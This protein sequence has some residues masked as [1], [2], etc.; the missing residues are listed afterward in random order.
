[1]PMEQLKTLLELVVMVVFIR[2]RLYWIPAA[3]PFLR[4]GETIF[5]KEI[6]LARLSGMKAGVLRNWHRRLTESNRIRSR[7]AGY[8]S[9]RLRLR[10]ASG[11]SHPYLRLPIFVSNADAKRELYSRS[12]VRGLGL[13]AAY[14]APVNEIPEIREAFA[15]E[16]FPVARRVADTLLTIP[17]HEWLSKK[18][19]RAIVDCVGPFLTTGSDQWKRG[20][21]VPD[22]SLKADVA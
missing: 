9:R 2:P 7:N 13:S 19:R 1:L 10:P 22:V 3:L 16:Q 4:L 6:R 12:Q 5:P 21:A 18:D 14:P 20:T 15:T 17:T 8:F 11:P